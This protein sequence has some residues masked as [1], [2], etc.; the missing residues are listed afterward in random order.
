MDAYLSREAHQSLTALSLMNSSS[1]PDGLLIG[2]K[3]GYRFFVEKV[4]PVRKGLYLPLKTYHELDELYE[5]KLLGFFSFEPEEKKIKNILAPFAYGKLFL[6]INLN[7]QKKMTF[8][9]YV[10][11]YEKEF[12]LKSVKLKNSK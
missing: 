6:E 8:K 9:S 4:F 3:R 10:I 1:I 12:F 11:E 2:H 5:G 7:P